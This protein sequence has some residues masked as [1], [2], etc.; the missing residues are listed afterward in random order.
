M[1]AEAT[2]IDGRWQLPGSSGAFLM[3][4]AGKAVQAATTE[5][6]AKVPSR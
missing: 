3:I 1:N 2:E 5:Q 4:R 6:H